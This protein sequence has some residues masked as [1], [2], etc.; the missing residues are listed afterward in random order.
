MSKINQ[1]AVVNFA[2]TTATDNTQPKNEL[3]TK[4]KKQEIVDP[5]DKRKKRNT[6][7]K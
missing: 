3:P 7:L 4:S 2:D 1:N 6:I 5:D